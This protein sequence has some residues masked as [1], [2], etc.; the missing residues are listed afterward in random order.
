MKREQISQALTSDLSETAASSA[1][2]RENKNKNKNRKLRKAQAR[3]NDTPAVDD[4][5]GSSLDPATQEVDM[6]QDTHFDEVDR[7]MMADGD[8]EE[9]VAHLRRAVYAIMGEKLSEAHSPGR[10]Q[11]LPHFT[12]DEES[13]YAGRLSAALRQNIRAIPPPPVSLTQSEINELK[14]LCLCLPM[15]A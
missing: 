3:A 12:T 6:I 7:L 9:I 2:R 13:E 8:P 11:G 15:V 10:E 4:A 14:S 5:A 1:K